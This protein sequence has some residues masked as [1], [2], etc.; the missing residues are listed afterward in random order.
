MGRCSFLPPSF[1]VDC[2][3]T[4]WSDA[5]RM[6]APSL[7]GTQAPSF[8]ENPHQVIAPAPVPLSVHQVSKKKQSTHG[9]PL[10]VPQI[11]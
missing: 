11:G 2:L 5:Q 9:T 1:K 10:L 4:S 8:Q 3:N 7:Q 6:G